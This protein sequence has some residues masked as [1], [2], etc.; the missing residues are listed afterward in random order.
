MNKN[1]LTLEQLEIVRNIL[2]DFENKAD[3]LRDDSKE[4]LE[5]ITTKLGN[6][7]RKQK[8]GLMQ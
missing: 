4:K 1:K 6:Q 7:I 3:H 5:E 8:F 2:I